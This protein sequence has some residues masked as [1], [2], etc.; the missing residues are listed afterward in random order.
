ML[1]DTATFL[2]L[3]VA[4]APS[5]APTTLLAVARAESGLDPFAIGVNGP[6]HAAPGARTASEAV[7]RAQDLVAAGQDVDLGLTQIN[8]RNLPRLGLTLAQAFD[9]CRNL[10]ASAR[11]LN[12]GYRR[13][14]PATGP[15]QPALRV[16]L[17]FYNTGRPDRGFRNGYVAKV[18]AKATA[19]LPVP[20]VVA[21]AGPRRAAD[22]DVFGRTRLVVADLIIK[23]TAGA[24]P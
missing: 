17:S 18:I 10:A 24:Q 2:S 9:P 15:G 8:V 14:L 13:A 1:L 5:V 16:A 11:I 12:E 20:D 22:W 21:G 19:T 7:H 4:C 3:A 6:P 23:P